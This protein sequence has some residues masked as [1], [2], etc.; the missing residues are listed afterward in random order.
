MIGTEGDRRTEVKR[1]EVKRTEVKRTE[2]KRTGDE[3]DH[4]FHLGSSR[5]RSGEF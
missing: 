4:W 3:A 5:K 1:T 2:V